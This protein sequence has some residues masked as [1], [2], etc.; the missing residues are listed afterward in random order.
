MT[1][2]E[3]AR[4]GCGS[5]SGCGQFCD[6]PYCLPPYLRKLHEQLKAEEKVAKEKKS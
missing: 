6:Y 2:E 1:L 4:K 3:I 5:C